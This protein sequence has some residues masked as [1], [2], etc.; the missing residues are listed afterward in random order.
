MHSFSVSNEGWMGCFVS[1]RSDDRASVKAVH[2]SEMARTAFTS[3]VAT[4]RIKR[5]YIT[6][7]EEKAIAPLMRHDGHSGLNSS[8]RCTHSEQKTCPQ[9]VTTAGTLNNCPQMGLQ[10]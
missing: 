4:E 9:R 1:A 2:M 10:T 5:C 8:E 3:D 6:L 7:T